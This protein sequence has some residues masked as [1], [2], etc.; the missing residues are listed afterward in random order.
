MSK[1]LFILSI[2]VFLFKTETVFS[3]E[4]IYDVN[5]I[6]VSGKLNS[7]LDNNKLIEEAFRKAFLIFINKTLLEKDIET[8]SKTNIQIIKDFIFT[9]QITSQ[10][11]SIDEEI[12]LTVNVKF[13]PKKINNYLSINNISYA[14]ISEISIS[15]LPI[16]R[17]ENNLFIF[18]DNFF[19]NE[20]NKTENDKKNTE[21]QL[22]NYN[23][24]LENAEDLFYINNN[25]ENL[26]LIDINKLNSL[27]EEKNKIFLIFTLNED[28]KVFIKAYFNEKEVIKN[29]TL[30]NNSTD[31]YNSLIMNVKDLINQIW[32][33]QN[34]I[35]INTPAYLDIIFD[36]KKINDFLKFRTFLDTIDII[37]NY[38][39]LEITNKYAKIRMKYKGKISN[40]REKFLNEKIN[41]NI[42]N[43]EWSLSFN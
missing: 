9:H 38:S 14:D 34:L 36:I 11:K 12:I 28:A 35:D 23:L 24:A 39:I 10:K 29:I 2:I 20:W 42:E 26:E 4:T 1:Y 6:Q 3:A 30:N 41:I 27:S 19:Y 31:D 5:N 16:L 22:I 7:N 32:K 17:K 15:I 13:D 40:L 21:A 25:K 33:E 18:S 43:N 8:L 37:D